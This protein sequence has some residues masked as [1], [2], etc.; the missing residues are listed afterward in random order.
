AAEFAERI[1]ILKDGKKF[2]DGPTKE[3]LSNKRLLVDAGLSPLQVTL[4]AESMKSYGISENT[5]RTM[6]FVEEF[7]KILKRGH[8]S[9]DER[10]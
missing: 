1:I 7:L 3:I 6:E 9:R 5:V 2:A 4:L 10:T 8:G